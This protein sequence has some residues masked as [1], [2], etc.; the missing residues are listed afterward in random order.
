[1]PSWLKVGTEITFVRHGAVDYSVAEDLGLI[2]H[3]F[4]LAPL[5]DDGERQVEAL[6]AS[7][8]P[9]S[10]DLIVSS[11]MTRALQT[12]A[13]IVGTLRLPLAVEMGLREWLP[14]A[15]QSWSGPA[16]PKAAG[17]EMR[18]FGGEWPPGETRSWEPRSSPWKSSGSCDRIRAPRT[19]HRR[20]SSDRRGM[21]R[22]RH[23]R[24]CAVMRVATGAAGVFVT[25]KASA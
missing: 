18:R 7:L 19:D 12:A 21:P 11:P 25:P 4:D 5:S 20:H 24:H 13:I 22:W 10:F 6:A 14:D 1:M 9:R 15:T 8:Y 3:G 16:V 2:G 23:S 17:R